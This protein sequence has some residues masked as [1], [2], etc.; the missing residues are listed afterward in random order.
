MYQNET[1]ACPLKKQMNTVKL[2]LQWL[3]PSRYCL[4]IYVIDIPSDTALE[5]T[6]FFFI[7]YQIFI[8]SRSISGDG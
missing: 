1:K 7:R 6:Y 4:T 5:E 2:A 3:I 8:A